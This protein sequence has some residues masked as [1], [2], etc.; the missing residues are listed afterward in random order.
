VSK[1]LFKFNSSKKLL[2]FL[3]NEAV[4]KA[5]KIENFTDTTGKISALGVLGAA[6]ASG[7]ATW[8]LALAA[9][10]GVL[11]TVKVGLWALRVTQDPAIDV[12]IFELSARS[13][14]YLARR[15]RVRTEDIYSARD[16]QVLQAIVEVNATAFSGSV[17]YIDKHQRRQVYSMWTKNDH[18]AVL[19]LT[20]PGQGATDPNSIVATSIVYA[21]NQNGKKRYLEEGVRPFLLDMNDLADANKPGDCVCLVLQ[22]LVRNADHPS[23]SFTEDS[24]RLLLYQVGLYVR[25]EPVWPVLVVEAISGKMAKRL[26]AKGFSN[27]QH[28]LREGD[29]H[30]LWQLDLS[31]A[32]SP[33]GA[34]LISAL[35][36]VT[37]AEAHVLDDLNTKIS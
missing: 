6:A 30:T 37:T 12:K 9:I 5:S 4:Q 28:V 18:R 11:V 36:T 15:E 35:R 26:Q 14:L 22:T 16:P 31:S 19:A 1:R 8:A 32:N 7:G 25:D 21:L 27:G 3:T 29:V 20:L 23:I 24:L 10:P 34:H 17:K 13:A 2:Y 33:A